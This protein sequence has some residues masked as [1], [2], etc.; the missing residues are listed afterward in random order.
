MFQLGYDKMVA[1]YWKNGKQCKGFVLIC[2][3]FGTDNQKKMG[4]PE[5]VCYPEPQINGF[6]I[7]GDTVWQMDLLLDV[8]LGVQLNTIDTCT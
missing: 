1:K 4:A 2:S 5:H 8:N 3:I 6:V 7:N